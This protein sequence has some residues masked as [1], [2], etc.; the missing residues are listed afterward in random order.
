MPETTCVANEENI[1][2][3]EGFHVNRRVQE[4]AERNAMPVFRSV[5]T[6]LHPESS[7]LATA[8]VKIGDICTIR[9]VKIKENDYGNEVVMPRTKM[10]YDTGYKDACFFESREVREQFGQSVLQAYEVQMNPE[11]R[12]EPGDGMRP[13]PDDLETESNDLDL[14]PDEG[15]G[16]EMRL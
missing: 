12:A 15:D 8:E 3:E 11:Y 2:P 9:N 16:P 10:P 6:N 13:E 5:I 1:H 4:P 7:V 14:E